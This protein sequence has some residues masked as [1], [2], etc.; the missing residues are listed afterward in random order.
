M[1][2]D[3]IEHNDETRKYVLRSKKD[4]SRNGML[5][6]FYVLIFI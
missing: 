5:S 2:I 4:Y 1:H 6:I 3:R